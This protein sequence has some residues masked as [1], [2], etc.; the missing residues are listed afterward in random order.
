MLPLG[1]YKCV[2]NCRS[3]FSS[4]LIGLIATKKKTKHKDFK[5]VLKC[6]GMTVLAE[7]L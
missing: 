1:L 7:R 4:C 5:E 3:V 2:F 6:F